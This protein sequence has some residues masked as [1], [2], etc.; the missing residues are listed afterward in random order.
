MITLGLLS[1]AALISMV[2][3]LVVIGLVTYYIMKT[4]KGF[5]LR[6]AEKLTLEKESN[7]LLSK[8]VEALNVRLQSIEQI[9]KEV[10]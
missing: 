9:L 5:E 1:L 10:E 2:L 6:A 3:P 8:E 7:A 4:V